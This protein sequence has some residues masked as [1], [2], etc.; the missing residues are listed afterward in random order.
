MTP[1]ENKI[2]TQN[3][4]VNN[5]PLPSLVHNIILHFVQW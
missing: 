5:D 2:L 1:Q 4:C 3:V